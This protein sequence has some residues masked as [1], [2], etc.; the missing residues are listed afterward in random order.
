MTS[1]IQQYMHTKHRRFITQA[2][3]EKQRQSASREKIARALQTVDREARAAVGPRGAVHEHHRCNATN[4]VIVESDAISSL[5]DER[6]PGILKFKSASSEA[7]SR[8]LFGKVHCDENALTTSGGGDQQTMI[9]IVN[10][11][12]E[13]NEVDAKQPLSSRR[14][15]EL[16]PLKDALEK[17]ATSDGTFQI[18]AKR[19]LYV[20]SNGLSGK[21]CG[22]KKETRFIAHQN[23]V[24]KPEAP[25]H[26]VLELFVQYEQEI[27]ADKRGADPM[28]VIETMETCKS[29]ESA[30]FANEDDAQLPSAN[31]AIREPTASIADTASVNQDDKVQI[32]QPDSNKA[33]TFQEDS[34]GASWILKTSIERKQDAHSMEGSISSADE[35]V[36]DSIRSAC[37]TRDDKAVKDRICKER[38]FS[39]NESTK[40]NLNELNVSR[41]SDE[42]DDSFYSED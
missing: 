30:S 17:F 19:Q 8:A 39:F 28:D 12:K 40:D 32:L 24:I 33:F 20:K 21:H 16:A 18:V 35:L 2:S 38:S 23:A 5:T 13:E 31:V 14:Q 6:P 9:E 11:E 3:L 26:S 25:L 27:Q 29:T 7:A 15:W 10:Y 42:Y 36:E 41:E 4:G 37:N 34:N 22:G 1:S